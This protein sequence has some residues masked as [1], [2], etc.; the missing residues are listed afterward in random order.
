MHHTCPN[1]VNHACSKRETVKFERSTA[2]CSLHSSSFARSLAH[3]FVHVWGE[4]GD[5]RGRAGGRRRQPSAPQRTHSWQP[6]PYRCE[7]QHKPIETSQHTG[8]YDA[9][10]VRGWG[11]SIIV[12]PSHFT[13][14]RAPISQRSTAHTS[15]RGASNFSARFPDFAALRKKRCYTRCF[16]SHS[17]LIFPEMEGPW[18]LADSHT[19]KK[20]YDGGRVRH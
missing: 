9:D 10:S 13:I 12:C 17:Y 6:M 5:G 19:A 14:D 4:V 7:Q 8:T 11:Y 2:T 16:N 15:H 20:V 1:T 3:P 18:S